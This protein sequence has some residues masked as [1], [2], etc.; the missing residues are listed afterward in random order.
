MAFVIY[1]TLSFVLDI[2]KL[3]CTDNFS[4]LFHS[5]N[6]ELLIEIREHPLFI[7]YD[8]RKKEALHGH[9][10]HVKSYEIRKCVILIC[11]RTHP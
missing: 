11:T 6:L 2:I 1:F 5:V 9:S 10:N 7:C 8:F 3:P 4:Y